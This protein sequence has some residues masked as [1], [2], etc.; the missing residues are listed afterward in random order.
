MCAIVSIVWAIVWAN[1]PGRR[2]RRRPRCAPWKEPLCRGEWEPGMGR[3][4][5]G[6]GEASHRRR[7]VNTR[8]REI[9]ADFS[10]ARAC[11]CA[12]CRCS[13]SGA[14]HCSWGQGCACSGR[15]SPSRPAQHGVSSFAD[16]GSRDCQA[17]VACECASERDVVECGR[18]VRVHRP[19]QRLRHSALK[20]GEVEGE[21]DGST[22]ESMLL[23]WSGLRGNQ[24]LAVALCQAP[25]RRSFSAL[26][27]DHSL[28]FCKAHWFYNKM[29]MSRRSLYKRE[30]CQRLASFSDSLQ[31]LFHPCS[32]E[33]TCMSEVKISSMQCDEKRAS[34]LPF[35]TELIRLTISVRI[36]SANTQCSSTIP[37]EPLFV[38]TKAC[39]RERTEYRIVVSLREGVNTCR[40]FDCLCA[41]KIE[42]QEVN[43]SPH[44]NTTPLVKSQPIRTDVVATQNQHHEIFRIMPALRSATKSLVCLLRS[45]TIPC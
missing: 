34:G 29:H 33:G 11:A 26:D 9:G 14:T 15:S 36:G 42:V 38:T 39:L 6:P 24:R 10:S 13:F 21:Q 18:E 44:H 4:R 22:S 12:S 28:S 17:A 1:G 40:T 32:H 30:L 16:A 43:N 7:R 23:W 45:E 2:R 20:T 31:V 25:I 19:R 5:S 27:E 37:N 41:P 3:V 8:L 35:T